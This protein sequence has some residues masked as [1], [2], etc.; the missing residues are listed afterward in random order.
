VDYLAGGVF[1]ELSDNVDELFWESVLV[2][3]LPDDFP[4]DAVEHLLEVNEDAVQRGSTI[5][6]TAR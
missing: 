4:V 1:L 2:H 3:Q 6:G 5:P